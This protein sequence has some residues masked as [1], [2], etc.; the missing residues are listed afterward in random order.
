MVIPSN[1][2]NHIEIKTFFKIAQPY[3]LLLFIYFRVLEI[4]S[5][6]LRSLSF[7]KPASSSH[8]G[9]SVF[10]NSA[11]VGPAWELGRCLKVFKQ[12]NLDSQ[13]VQYSTVHKKKGMEMRKTV[14]MRQDPDLMVLWFYSPLLVGA[15][16]TT[17]ILIVFTLT[18]TW[19]AAE[20][21]PAFAAVLGSLRKRRANLW[22]DLHPLPASFPSWVDRRGTPSNTHNLCPI[23]PSLHAV[24]KYSGTDQST[25]PVHIY[26][27]RLYLEAKQKKWK[28]QKC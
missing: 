21:R 24:G 4:I 14:R 9:N 23:T 12:N 1:I 15:G 11:I 28:R 27:H 26:K 2:A 3:F 22:P 20:E 18:A 5:F 25:E 6:S 16:L 13:S 17:N 10:Q 19:G 7:P 8:W